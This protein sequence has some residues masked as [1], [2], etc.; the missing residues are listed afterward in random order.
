M[1]AKQLHHRYKSSLFQ[2]VQC[3]FKIPTRR[4]DLLLHFFRLDHIYLSLPWPLPIHRCGRFPQILQ[5]IAPLEVLIWMNNRLKLRR[6]PCSVVFDF[7]NL[8]GVDIFEDSAGDLDFGG[9]END[10][11]VDRERR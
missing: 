1:N 7:L 6:S 8:A 11:L 2:P 5:K 3:A 4:N 10:R 9:I